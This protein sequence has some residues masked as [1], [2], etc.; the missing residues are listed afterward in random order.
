MWFQNARQKARKVFEQQPQLLAQA[1]QQHLAAT[2]TATSSSSAEGNDTSGSIRPNFQC[3]RCQQVFGRYLE[4]IQH[5]QRVCFAAERTATDSNGWLEQQENNPG[6]G[7]ERGSRRG[8]ETSATMLEQSTQELLRALVA[9][10]QNNASMAMTEQE[11]S[12]VNMG[13]GGV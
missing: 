9:Q 1:H 5:Q 10:Q 8:S 11:Q 2:A 4:M 13:A 3:A 7:G 12:Q 6:G